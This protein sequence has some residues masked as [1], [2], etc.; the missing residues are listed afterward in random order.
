[1]TQYQKPYPTGLLLKAIDRLPNS[2][3][4]L[5]DSEYSKDLESLFKLLQ[6]KNQQILSTHNAGFQFG[7][8]VNMI[9]QVTRNQDNYLQGLMCA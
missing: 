4:E 3:Q 5:E 6:S 2:I 9:I 8:K 1:M 7:S